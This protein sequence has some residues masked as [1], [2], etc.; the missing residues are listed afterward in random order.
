[1]LCISKVTQLAVV[2]ADDLLD[3]Y[4]LVMC[5]YTEALLIVIG[6]Q[7]G[8]IVSLKHRPL[9]YDAYRREDDEDRLFCFLFFAFLDKYEFLQSKYYS[10]FTDYLM[11]R[12]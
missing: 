3:K 6:L 7:T 4:L 9:V 5:V 11:C 8:R 12:K 10:L 1:M 2:E